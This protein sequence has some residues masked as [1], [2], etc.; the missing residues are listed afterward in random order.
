MATLPQAL[1][2]V[3]PQSA[4]SLATEPKRVIV[5]SLEIRLR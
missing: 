1:A 3:L 4:L 2:V 5:Q